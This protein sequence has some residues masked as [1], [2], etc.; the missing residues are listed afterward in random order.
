MPSRKEY[1]H[2]LISLMVYYVID[3]FWGTFYEFRLIPLLW[4]VT[5]LYFGSMAVSVFLWTRYVIAYLNREKKFKT[6]LFFM[7]WIFMLL[8]AVVLVINCFHPIV[9][10]FLEDKTYQPLNMRYFTLLLQVLLYLSTAIYTLHASKFSKGRAR[11]RFRTVGISGLPLAVLIAGQMLF[12]FL[13]LYAVGCLLG[14]CIMHTFVLEEEKSDYRRE[15]ERSL[16]REKRQRIEL[17]SAQNIMDTD[18]LTG[19]KSKYAFLKEEEVL[20]ALIENGGIRELCVIVF[21]LNDL[22][23]VNDSRGHEEGDRY[24]TDACFM[25]CKQFSHSPVYRIGGDEFVAI[26]RDEDFRNRRFLFS[27]FEKQMEYNQQHGDVVIATGMEDFHPGEDKHFS[28]VFEK[29][30]KNMY[31]RK[32]YLKHMEE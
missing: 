21:D 28:S 22:K 10:T 11:R 13:P 6:I 23:A 26:L 31:E 7:G 9:F 30:D 25:I 17:E 8:E 19:V 15:L 29:A 27:S 4:I 2:F 18:P 16:E 12:P 14:V 24:I 3:A 20:E 1:R 32:A 5:T